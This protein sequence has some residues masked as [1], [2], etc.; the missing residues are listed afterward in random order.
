MPSVTASVAP[1]TALSVDSGFKSRFREHAVARLDGVEPERFGS[2]RE[3]NNFGFNARGLFKRVVG[4]EYD[5][6]GRKHVSV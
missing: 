4:R 1:A 2:L 3:A 6:A 5:T